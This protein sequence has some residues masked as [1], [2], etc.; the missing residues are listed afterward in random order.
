MNTNS[1][2]A[3]ESN[4]GS[5][6]TKNIKACVPIVIATNGREPGGA[7][8]RTKSLLSYFVERIFWIFANKALK[9]RKIM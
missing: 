4:A 3:L 1:V 6:Y 7:I 2:A 9:F 8:I 5:L